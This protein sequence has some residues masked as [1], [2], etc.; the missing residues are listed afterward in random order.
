MK[1]RS[2]LLVLSLM[3]GLSTATPVQSQEPPP[4]WAFPVN[5]PDFK[6]APD[7]GSLRRVP[8]ST[9]TYTLTQVRDLFVAPV[10]H[11]ADH[12]PCQRWS[13]M[14]GS[15]TY[16]RVV[17]VIGQTGLVAPKILVSRVSPRRTSFSKWPIS[18]VVPERV[19]CR[20][21]FRSSL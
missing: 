3:A 8:G 21:D 17:F 12:P 15:P 7:D 6:P 2:A 13:R 4:A 14:V 16:R 1:T 18:G 10:W 20:K 5:P 9:A 11:P 19:Q